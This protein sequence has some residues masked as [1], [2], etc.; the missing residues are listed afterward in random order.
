MSLSVLS[1]FAGIGGLDLGLQRA[2]MRIAAQVERDPW[3]RTVLETHFPE[4]D[5]H[6]DVRTTPTWW[7]SRPRPAIDV[8]AGGFPCQPFSTAGTHQG[9]RD[10]RWGWPWMA[11]VLRLVRPR[12][13]LVENVPALL[14]DTDA[15]GTI[16]AD[17]AQLGFDAQWSLLSACSLGAPHTR[18]RLFL[19]AHPASLGRGPRWSA[20]TQPTPMEP[21]RRRTP[22]RRT[23]ATESR[24]RGVAYGVP[25]GM[26]RRQAL[27]N[28]VLPQAGEHLA[29]LI[30][31]HEHQQ[32]STA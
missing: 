3:C 20:R 15:F 16:L 21:H 10:Q 4:A 19:L 27:G 8:V 18:Q 24:P 31:H 32:V 12:Y 7:Q 11:D 26:D 1:L 30:H 5:R 23:W 14:A 2:G 6:D 28:A 17:L 22:P 13:V 25:A 29:Q 9:T